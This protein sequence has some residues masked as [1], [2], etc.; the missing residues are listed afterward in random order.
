MARSG[1]AGHRGRS[2][3]A[4][5]RP[6]TASP[7]YPALMGEINVAVITGGSSGIG[8]ALA[9]KLVARGWQ[10]VLL[11]RGRKRLEKTAN[12][13]GAEAEQCD[14]SDRDG[15]ERSA[16]AIRERHPKVKALVNNAGIPGGGGY[17]ELDSERIEQ[18]T[19]INYLGGVWCLRAFLPLLEAGA[20]SHVVNVTSIAAT[21]P[22]GPS[23]P[24]S[25]AKHAQLAFSRNVS[26]ELAPRGIHVHSV[27]PA[28]TATEG[29]PQTKMLNGGWKRR[30][31]MPPEQVA[32]AIVKAIDHDST[33]VYVPAAY[34]LAG[35]IHS[36]APGSWS[37]LAARRE[38][39][40]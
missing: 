28:F 13:L 24:Y 37:R 14:V 5:N 36:L 25:A 19:N 30:L 10:C 20:P 16:E 7:Q 4:S 11:A 34:R 40:R 1:V 39:S 17:L 33:E 22:L 3:R 2:S 32:D 12:T 9:R 27:N 31:V 23:G 26:A 15:V 38:R 29:F 8:A 35:V 6:G 18:L 21:V